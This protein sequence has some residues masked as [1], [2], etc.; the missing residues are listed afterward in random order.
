MLGQQR[1]QLG[2]L[3]VGIPADPV[4]VLPA[5]PGRRG[6]DRAHRVELAAAAI[7]VHHGERR[8]DP[9]PLLRGHRAGGVGIELVVAGELDHGIDV[10][11]AIGRQQAIRQL[12]HP[13]DP[14]GL[15]NIERVD[16]VRRHPGH[17]G[18]DGLVGQFDPIA[19][20][21][22]ADLRGRD[23]LVSQS[24]R[25]VDRAIDT[26]REAPGAFVHHPDREPEIFAVA[27]GIELPVPQRERRRA[28]AFE[29]EVGVLGA[30]VAGPLQRGI[31]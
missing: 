1:R 12:G 26:G 22:R 13:G 19:A 29:P 18:V 16:V 20:Q 11:D 28:D 8:V 25:T 30:Q 31:G 3:G 9:H 2:D 17:I 27:A 14:L 23:R 24:H 4:Q 21:H 15:R 6:P 5:A 10:I 7:D